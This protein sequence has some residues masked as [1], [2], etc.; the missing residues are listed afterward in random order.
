[1]NQVPPFDATIDWP[2]EIAGMK[3]D[4]YVAWMKSAYWITMTL[5]PAISVPAG[6]TAG[7]A[8]RRHPDRRPLPRR[9]RLLQIAHA[10]EQETGFGLERPALAAHFADLVRSRASR[11]S[12]PS[13]QPGGS[14]H[15]RLLV[16]LVL[17]LPV[18][19]HAAV[20]FWGDKTSQPIGVAAEQ[21]EPGRIRR[22][23]EAATAGPIVVVVDL[24]DQIA[25]VYRNGIEIGY[26]SVSTGRK[27]YRTPTGCSS[28]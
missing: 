24:D 9:F 10:F 16:A 27:G 15:E 2:K 6:F 13:Q 26:S 17:A 1:M 22:D 20:P 28:R 23:P 21:L 8:A 19:A 3:M 5:C 4:H 11:N 18:L 25:H 14:N 12:V 7:R